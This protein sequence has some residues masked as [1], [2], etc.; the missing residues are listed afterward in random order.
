MM[1][2]QERNGPHEKLRSL[3]TQDE[4]RNYMEQHHQQMRERSRHP[5]A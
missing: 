4:C 5:P 3:H 2:P 1:T